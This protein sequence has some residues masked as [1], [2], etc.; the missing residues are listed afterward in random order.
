MGR[1]RH[2]VCCLVKGGHDGYET[3][4]EGDLVTGVTRNKSDFVL[5]SDLLG[6]YYV[7]ARMYV[8]MLSVN[9]TSSN[10]LDGF[11]K[12]IQKVII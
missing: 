7:I 1:Q 4:A 5:R 6:Y 9:I 2:V 8:C 10:P 12:K 11:L 3:T